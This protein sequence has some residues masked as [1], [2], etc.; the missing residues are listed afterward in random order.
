[1]LKFPALEGKT[2]LV[3]VGAS[4]CA[5]SCLHGYLD[6]LPA[7]TVSPLKEVHFF[8]AKF[9][10][11]ALGDMERLALGRLKYHLDQPG[12]PL[13]NMQARPNFRASID[14]AQMVYDDNAYFAHFARLVSPG[15]RVFCDITPAYA[16]IG[17]AGFACMRDFAAAQGVGLK[18]LFIMRDPVTRFWSQL[19]Q[20]EQMNPANNALEKWQAALASAPLMS[21]ADYRATISAMEATDPPDNLLTLFYEDLTGTSALQRLCDFA[22][23]EYRPPASRTPVN[24]TT[25]ETPLPDAARAAIRE[26]LDDQYRYCRTRFGVDVPQAWGG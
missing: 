14:R 21:R 9:P 18:L 7:A 20:L 8:N 10:Q 12:D 13:D 3:C 25:V 26:A 11:N 15:T 23:L 4:K 17:E 19:R 1:L 6:S 24:Q 5:T 16:S 2:L 22:G